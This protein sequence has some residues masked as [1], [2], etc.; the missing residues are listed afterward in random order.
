MQYKVVF[1]LILH[2]AAQ[3]YAS[4][5][6]EQVADGPADALAYELTDPAGRVHYLIGTLHAQR[7]SDTDL[8]PR[9][10]DFWDRV[11]TVLL[12]IDLESVSRSEM[13]AAIQRHALWSGGGSLVEAIG[14]DA[15]A[16]LRGLVSDRGTYA[17]VRGF[18][19]WFAELFLADILIKEAEL[20]RDTGLDFLLLKAARE[21]QKTVAGLETLEEQFASLASLPA[22]VQVRSLRRSLLEWEN[23]RRELAELYDHY[24]QGRVVEIARL[25]AE[26]W[27]TEPD[28]SREVIGV[29]NRRMAER[30][31][32]RAAEGQR[33]L[34]AVGLG[35]L[36]GPQSVGSLLRDRGWKVVPLT[37]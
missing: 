37:F 9:V 5:K 14:E 13:F 27:Q 4:G 32:L 21:R 1:F 30:V 15:A 17:L 22:E 2:V 31:A 28:F 36:V 16:R 33:L 18:Q 10:N 8:P 3:A 34:V 19:P 23:Q 25:L 26:L 11:D 20:T 29:R 12:E 7:P 6:R 24:R 35:H